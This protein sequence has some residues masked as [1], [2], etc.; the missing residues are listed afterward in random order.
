MKNF[1]LVKRENNYL[2]WENRAIIKVRKMY[3]Q[4]GPRSQQSGPQRMED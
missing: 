4:Q 1:V 3:F 2:Y